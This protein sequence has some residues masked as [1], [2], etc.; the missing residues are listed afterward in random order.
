[1]PT[2][3]K[4][5]LQ[6]LVRELTKLSNE[7]EWVEF[8]CNNKEPQMIGEY[9][10]AISNSAALC[11]K[12][13]GYLVWGVDDVKHDIV[14]TNFQYRKMKKGNEELEAWLSRM[15]SPR[16]N[17]HFYEVP[18]DSG[19]VVLLEIPCA[20]KQPVQFSG[21]EYIRIGTNK[22]KLKEYPDKERELWR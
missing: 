8:K 3:S 10:S 13:K 2:R 4:E 18:F 17:F 7:T 14:G 11:D 1:M 19:Q 16:I 21:S 20:E 15:L 5:Y 12:P 6:S 9:I 22:K